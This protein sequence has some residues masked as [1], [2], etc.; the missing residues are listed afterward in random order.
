M[1]PKALRSV[2]SHVP[3]VLPAYKD[4]VPAL[5]WR[6][7]PKLRGSFT[8][9]MEESRLKGELATA[10]QNASSIVAVIDRYFGVAAQTLPPNSLTPFRQI[11]TKEKVIVQ[12]GKLY[13]MAPGEA[14][15][16]RAEWTKMLRSSTRAL[17]EVFCPASM[18]AYL[19]A[20]PCVV[21]D[22]QL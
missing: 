3:A 14:P 19:S 8:L 13:T 22:L 10:P 7:G 20:Q 6:Q 11:S 21:R 15:N 17:I 5:A 9:S 4:N 1:D 18:V 16:V 2:T 12:P